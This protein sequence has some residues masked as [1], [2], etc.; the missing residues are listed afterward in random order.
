MYLRVKGWQ[1]KDNGKTC[2]YSVY[3]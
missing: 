3:L 1:I 2:G